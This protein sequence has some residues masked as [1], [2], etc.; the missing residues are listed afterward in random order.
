MDDKLIPKDV[1]VIA[2]NH[3]FLGHSITA[4]P[5]LFSEFSSTVQQQNNWLTCFYHGI[6]WF[7]GDVLTEFLYSNLRDVA[8]TAGQI[9][10]RG[11]EKAQ[12]LQKITSRQI[13]NFEVLTCPPF[14]KLS[15]MRVYCF[16]HGIKK[17][18]YYICALNNEVKLKRW[19][20]KQ[21]KEHQLC[22][23]TS[24]TKKTVQIPSS[25]NPK[26]RVRAVIADVDIIERSTSKTDSIQFHVCEDVPSEN[27]QP[28]NTAVSSDNRCSHS[29]GSPG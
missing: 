27:E 25:K 10:T 4:P 11:R 7:E 24:K 15:N 14:K 17:E 26:T 16:Y 22:S 5:H 20:E 9:Y 3:M 1:A 12:P 29:W 13:V 28:R 23:I 21:R 2:L 8:K 18:E 19:I 6:E